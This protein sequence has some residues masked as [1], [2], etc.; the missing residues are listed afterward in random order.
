MTLLNELF[1]TQLQWR[2]PLLLWA[3]MM[4]AVFWGITRL[5]K[6]RQQ[7]TYSDA[8]LW[9][10]VEGSNTSKIT[11]KPSFLQMF[12]PPYSASILLTLAWI[13]LIIALAGPKS[14]VKTPNTQ[15]R[16]GIDLLVSMDLSHSMTANDYYPNRFL[17][18][19]SLVET[20]QNQLEKEDRLALQAFA[21]QP[22]IVSPLSYDH[23]LFQHMLNLLEP[24]L[25]PLQGTWVERA[26]IE[27]LEHLS[28]SHGDNRVL[29]LFTNGSP[30]FWT[31]PKLPLHLQ[32]SPFFRTATAVKEQ[33][34]KLIIVGIGG[35]TPTP[36]FEPNEANKILHINAQPI[37]SKLEEKRLKEL[38]QHYGG[39]YLRANASASFMKDLLKEITN[40]ARQH[41][42]PS[43][44]TVW[45]DYAQPFIIA[46]L[47]LLIMAFYPLFI[48]LSRRSQKNN[49]TLLWLSGLLTL[50]LYST[51]Q[52]S[53][54]QPLNQADTPS[55]SLQQAYRAYQQQQ[56][57][58][59]LSQYR[60]V[61]NY[62]GYFGSGSSAY[63]LGDIET[64]VF[65]FRQ[66]AWLANT[67]SER[68]K[69]LFNLGNSYYQIQL[70][71]FAILSYQQ[72]LNYQTHYSQAQNNL[73]LAQAQKVAH[74]PMNQHN[75]QGKEGQGD[76]TQSSHPDGAFYGGQQPNSSNQNELGFGSDGDAK[77]GDKQGNQ[78]VISDTGQTI[79][80]QLSHSGFQA[81]QL[82]AYADQI[83]SAPTPQAKNLVEQQYQQQLTARFKQHIEQLEDHQKTLL[84]RLFEREAGFHA[85]QEQPHSI[86]GIQPW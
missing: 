33:N 2:E 26:L 3:L 52:T 14:L 83:L 78:V 40:N 27:G 67:D 12:F 75:N 30:K 66:A 82:N 73:T 61:K 59:S 71:D 64:A 80:Y 56:Y 43:T 20:M 8:H 37:Q 49:Y 62:Q 72:A 60:K 39:V 63:K 45:Q 21:G 10:W 15:S 69:A 23:A 35:L 84:K 47:I 38:S 70:F 57:E 79:N 53:Y 9:P 65:Y 17:F 11:A 7:H 25:L 6:K 31:P 50:S 46:G 74:Q 5:I 85:P 24:N 16:E 76:G 22:H 41:P 51:P 18:V 32:N 42:S 55:Q 48:K 1:N 44:H 4:P 54:A 29:I 34:I 77:E 68:A 19:K 13:C 81:V 36:L 28:H 58:Q 86:P